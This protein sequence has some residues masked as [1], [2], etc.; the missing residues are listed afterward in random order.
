MDEEGK[1]RGGG[2]ERDGPRGGGARR[3]GAAPPL[4]LSRRRGSRAA[5]ARGTRRRGGAIVA[6]GVCG[7]GV[8]GAWKTTVA[9]RVPGP[10][11]LA[12][13]N[14]V[15][16]ARRAP[17]AVGAAESETSSA[18]AVAAVTVPAAPPERETVFAAGEL[19]SKPEPEMTSRRAAEPGFGLELETAT[20][21]S[22]A[23]SATTGGATT[24]ATCLAAP[25][26][27]PNDV[28]TA[29]SGPRLVDGIERERC[30][31]VAVAETTVA[32]APRPRET[33]FL[34][35][36][37][38]TS[39]PEPE[40]ASVGAFRAILRF[41][42]WSTAG[43]GTTVATCTVAPPALLL[44]SPEEVTEATDSGP[45]GSGN[46]EGGNVTVSEVAVAAKTVFATAGTNATALLPAAFSESSKPEPEMTSCVALLASVVA[47]LSETAGRARTVATW[48]GSPLD[49]PN[50]PAKL[51]TR[52]VSGPRLVG[53][54]E[55][56]S[57]SLE[58]LAVT[59]VKEPPPLLSST[60]FP[61]G[62]G[63]KPAPEM[64]RT[65]GGP[66][67]AGPPASVAAAFAW[68]L[69]RPLPSRGRIP[70]QSSGSAQK[71]L[72]QRSA[73]SEKESPLSQSVQPPFFRIV[74]FFQGS[75]GKKVSAEKKG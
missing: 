62:S 23:L 21:S 40:M 71:L 56:C 46:E 52:A 6:G 63:S 42:S 11:P 7:G 17:A 58:G 31:E 54:A 73:G 22:A 13:P 9:T 43:A 68:T 18:V 72:S 26:P 4:P 33:A 10:G 66:A 61:A 3:D 2:E 57:V 25:L 70:G 1:R 55:N 29:V 16:T 34:L 65:G 20:G 48:T 32:A 64:A 12:P 75:R 45:S 74:F 50:E 49:P 41:W 8:G 53:G 44:V 69:T 37:S 28:T 15:T 14:E 19:A 67:G 47:V 51:V 38:E 30:R 24:V 36:P 27:P 5:A 60:A 39:K 59:T 35:P